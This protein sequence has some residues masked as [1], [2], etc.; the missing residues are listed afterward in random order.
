MPAPA[1]GCQSA[2]DNSGNPSM[3]VVFDPDYILPCLS[4]NIPLTKLAIHLVSGLI[5]MLV[6]NQCLIGLAVFMYKHLAICYVSIFN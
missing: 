1:P 2:V 6:R 3:Y 4:L 5:S